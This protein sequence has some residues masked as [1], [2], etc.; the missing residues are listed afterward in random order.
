MFQNNT[1]I[2]SQN[3]LFGLG[4]IFQPLWGRRFVAFM[5]KQQTLRLHRSPTIIETRNS[6]MFQN[7]TQINSQNDLFG[8][9]GIVRPFWGSTIIKNLK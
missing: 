1:Q 7:N 8:L 4:R 9:G 5:E 6:F 3:D 2:N